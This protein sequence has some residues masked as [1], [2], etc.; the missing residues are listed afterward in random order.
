MG[1]SMQFLMAIL[2]LRWK[3]GYDAVKWFSDQI[4]TFINYSLEG[5]ATVFGDPTMVL[6]PFVFV[7]SFRR[8]SIYSSTEVLF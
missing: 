3:A 7:V 1:F 8:K 4:M 6:H 2:V 5:A